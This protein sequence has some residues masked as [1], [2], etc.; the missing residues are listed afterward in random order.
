[1]RLKIMIR[2]NKKLYIICSLIVLFLGIL[3]LFIKFHLDG[4]VAP[5]QGK[6]IVDGLG[7]PVTIL[8]DELG[9]PFIKAQS[10]EDVFYAIGYLHASERRWQ[11]EI[12]KRAG[13]GRV[14]ELLGNSLLDFDHF[15]RLIGLG[16]KAK[17]TLKY[18][19][20]RL[21]S[22]LSKYTQ[23]VNQYTANH[24]LPFEFKVLGYKPE[25]WTMADSIVVA[26]FMNYSLS[27]NLIEELAF[28]K[29]ASKLDSHKLAYLFP[30]HAD[31][32][33]P[34]NEVKKVAQF[35][36]PEMN[37]INLNGMLQLDSIRSIGLPASN[38]WAV[39]PKKS[40]TN[41][42]LLA[43]DTHLSI[44]MPMPWYIA[45]YQYPNAL[46]VGLSIPGYP[47]III[48]YNGKIAWG[49]TMA[50]VDSQDI[51]IEKMKQK[52]SKKYYLDGKQ[53]KPVTTWQEQIKV[54]NA[55]PKT[56]DIYI[57]G[58]GILLNDALQKNPPAEALGRLPSPVKSEY[59]IAL[60]MAER[61]QARSHNTF[62][63]MH[64][65][66]DMQK[67]RKAISQ[68][69]EMYVNVVY[70]DGQNIA[71]DITGNIPIRANGIGK[72]PSP[73][74]LQK[75][76]W[77]GYLPFNQKPSKY[78]PKDG[79]IATNNNKTVGPEYPHHIGSSW[80]SPYRYKRAR[81]MLLEYDQVDL[82]YFK[83]MQLDYKTVFIKDLRDKWNQVYFNKKL[84]KAIH[85]LRKDNQLLALKA[86]DILLNFDGNL[87]PSSNA[88]L[89]YSAFL[90]RYTKNVFLDELDSEDKSDWQAFSNV[91]IRS[92]D[93]IQDHLLVSRNSPFYD[94]THTKKK[95][96]EFD[97]IAISLVDAMKFCSDKMGDD[98]SSWH[99]GTLHTYDWQHIFTK[100]SK[101]LSPYLNRGPYEA[102]G[103]M[104]TL[105]VSHY[106][107]SRNNFNTFGI[108]AN[109]FLVDFSREEPVFL[110][111]T[112]GQ[113]GNP[114]SN[115]YDDML[116][117]FLSGK[118]HHLPL[119]NQNK[120]SKH[121]KKTMV[122]TTIK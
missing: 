117:L 12:M 17:V 108:P 98:P 112:S 16:R 59:G 80:F 58:N 51:F 110:S 104:H 55:K 62:S 25:K 93:A 99:W 3:I 68:L 89:V 86:L 46:M 103:D 66:T 63:L 37:T 56:I 81:E 33:L 9:V 43:N 109:R 95:E 54:K 52:G 90:Q 88:A 28:L 60:R 4:T 38:N 94:N 19:S 53:Y 84:L 15:M 32:Q 21:K 57:T 120:V 49:F 14:S 26:N 67:F 77:K 78:N 97:M 79:F 8:R 82:D 69:D 13:W 2:I 122:L 121:Y 113:S 64:T 35:V 10:E 114:Q 27:I 83:K 91:I 29:L 70:S 116:P 1:M 44:S 42:A 72:L 50:M 71:W 39:M 6:V 40:K 7:K 30:N 73:G 34:F 23:G 22:I 85:T 5:E 65:F 31:E 11:M 87:L 45:S 18:A 107:F 115:H 41:K 48:G 92:Y 106:F 24:S 102:G 96:N 101:L 20:H 76:R 36:H 75:Y 118:M 47:F 74:W 111:V 61:Y 100:K 105:N 119:H